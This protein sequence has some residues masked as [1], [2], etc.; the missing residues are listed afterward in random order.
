MSK[1]MLITVN[2][3]SQPSTWWEGAARRGQKA[4]ALLPSVVAQQ[5]FP[6]AHQPQPYI[7]HYKDGVT[8][9]EAYRMVFDCFF[10]KALMHHLDNIQNPAV[11]AEKA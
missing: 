8:A 1:F 2:A 4:L 10:R 9:A 11:K 5:H 3:E 7:L 6:M